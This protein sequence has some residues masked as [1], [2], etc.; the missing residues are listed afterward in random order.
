MIKWDRVEELY[1]GGSTGKVPGAG[2]DNGKVNR[3][4]EER[5]K[6]MLKTSTI[7]MLCAVMLLVLGVGSASAAYVEHTG[8]NDPET[9]GFTWG[10]T[11]Y[12]PPSTWGGTELGTDFWAI[13]DK[14][15]YGAGRYTYATTSAQTNNDWQISINLRTDGASAGN[16][17]VTLFDTMSFTYLLHIPPMSIPARY[18]SSSVV[19]RID[20]LTTVDVSQSK[21]I[22][23]GST[24]THLQLPGC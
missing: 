13:T 4:N 18:S 14:A 3:K 1:C 11:E 2:S 20:S 5:R 24:P 15:G 17:A 21:N 23:D 12:T 22:P 16:V 7:F 19:T 10:N 9:E 6:T 8:S